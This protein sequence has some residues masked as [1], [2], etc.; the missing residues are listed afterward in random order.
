MQRA[1]NSEH[2]NPAWPLGGLNLGES[3]FFTLFWLSW[4]NSEGIVGIPLAHHLMSD[5]K[6]PKIRYAGNPARS[7]FHKYLAT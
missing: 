4:N 2:H 7:F 6:N 3:R 5:T 1:T